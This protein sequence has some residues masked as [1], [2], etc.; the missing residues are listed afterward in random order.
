MRLIL[1]SASPA[2]LQTLRSAG[3]FPEVVISEVDESQFAADT[4]THLA[5]LLAE[6]KAEAVF[7]NLGSPKDSII[8]GCD[9]ILDFEGKAQGKPGSKEAAISLLKRT[10]RRS[11]VLVTGHHII[12][13]Q[14]EVQ[15]ANRAAK[16]II[17]VADLTDDEIDAYVTTG[18]PQHVAGG[19]TIDALG[20]PFI[21][22]IEGDPHNVVGLSLPLV[23]MML[24]DC[25]IQWTSL[26]TPHEG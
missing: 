11:G 20:G 8:I 13:S 5:C 2:R 19:F 22:G 3:T 12:V 21:T 10:R 9:S 24:A 23:R 6:K 1:A 16:T 15:R 4:P 14:D 18:E 25:G 17:H 26:W 7:A